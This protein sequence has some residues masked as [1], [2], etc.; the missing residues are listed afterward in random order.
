MESIYFM[1]DGDDIGRTIEAGILEERMSDL[2]TL[3][4]NISSALSEIE[5]IIAKEGGEIVFRGC[6]DIS[7]TLNKDCHQVL[8]TVSDAFH[9]MTGFT[10]TIGVGSTVQEAFLALRLGKC[11]SKG[12]ILFWSERPSVGG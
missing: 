3:T 1:L 7:G 10:A 6:D 11:V 8:K 5:R 4:S 2:H 12:G 9:I